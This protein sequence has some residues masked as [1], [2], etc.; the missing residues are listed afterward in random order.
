MK[1]IMGNPS[2]F[3]G[4]NNEGIL[5]H[6]RSS[7]SW[8]CSCAGIIRNVINGSCFSLKDFFIS[9]AAGKPMT[10]YDKDTSIKQGEIDEGLFL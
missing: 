4:G 6:F 1:F 8:R 2:N 10:L 9:Q 7:I 5:E 3:E